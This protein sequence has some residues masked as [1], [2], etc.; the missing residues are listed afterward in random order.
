MDDLGMNF[1]VFFRK[2]GD[3]CHRY[4]T[5]ILDIAD[6]WWYINH[7]SC[8]NHALPPGCLKWH[9]LKVWRLRIRM[10]MILCGI[11]LLYREL[12]EVV[13][14]AL[15]SRWF[16]MKSTIQILGIAHFKK[17]PCI[18]STF[19]GFRL[20]TEVSCSCFSWTPHPECRNS[21]ECASS[22]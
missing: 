8:F 19:W 2:H 15:N 4:H 18:S 14:V 5:D 10:S 12:C 3:V 9:V 21:S 16:S 11:T 13:V 1:M 6:S 20:V 7:D 22:F 17:A